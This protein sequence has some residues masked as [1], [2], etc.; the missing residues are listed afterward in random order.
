[1]DRFK[2]TIFVLCL[3]CSFGTGVILQL[4]IFHF[5]NHKK[6]KDINRYKNGK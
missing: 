2:F 5:R 6:N 4:L 3:V 1:M